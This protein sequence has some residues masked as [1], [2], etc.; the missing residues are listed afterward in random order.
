MQVFI[1]SISIK[2]WIFLVFF[3]CFQN[4]FTICQGPL[5]EL[6]SVDLKCSYRSY[7]IIIGNW[8]SWK[9]FKML[10]ICLFQLHLYLY[11]RLICIFQLQLS[12]EVW[13][14]AAVGL[15]TASQHRGLWIQR[16][17]RHYRPPC[18]SAIW[19]NTFANLH[20]YVLQVGQ[21]HF[22]FWTNIVCA[23]QQRGLWIQ[24]CCRHLAAA[25]Q[26]LP[27]YLHDNLKAGWDS[28]THFLGQ[29]LLVQICISSLL[30]DLHETAIFVSAEVVRRGEGWEEI[31]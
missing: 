1:Q 25:V 18:S 10:W 3:Q 11:M 28:R 31:C 29:L 17:C 13:C 27:V 30:L 5:Q 6:A 2:F 4:A 7:E 8:K 16:C 26:Q 23:S 15:E 22:A 14:G 20:K 24:S 12:F 21:I 9:H 19:T